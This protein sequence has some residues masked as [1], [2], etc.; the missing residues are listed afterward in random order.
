MTMHPIAARL[1]VYLLLAADDDG[2]T[3]RAPEILDL[4]EAIAAELS[5]AEFQRYADEYDDSRV[6]WEVSQAMTAAFA[7]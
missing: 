3:D 2:S 4:A 6:R 5:E 1:A 7:N